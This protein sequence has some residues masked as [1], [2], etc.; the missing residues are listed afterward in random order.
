VTAPPPRTYGA[1][2]TE[3]YDRTKPVGGDYPDVPYY[4][5]R[6]A[7]TRGPILEAA[8]GTGRL[9]VPMLRAGLAMTGVDS[10][11]SMLARC[12]RNCA[13]AGVLARLHLGALETMDLPERYEAIVL[14]FGSFLLLSGPGEAAAALARMRQHLVAGGRVFLDVDAPAASASAAVGRQSRREVALE[15]GSTI[16]LIDTATGYDTARRVERHEQCYEWWREGRLLARELLDFPLRRYDLGEVEAMLGEA[17]FVNV[18]AC[19]DYSEE[20]PAATGR[21]WQCFV[22]QAR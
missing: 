6:L 19:G 15:D 7:S 18:A 4:L 16:V 3:F 1:L 14:T 13:D 12:R 2:C 22:G 5:R 20:K 8:V 10:S 17:G 11:E 9:L 21:E